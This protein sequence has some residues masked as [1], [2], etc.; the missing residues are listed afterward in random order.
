MAVEFV[1]KILDDLKE[2]QEEIATEKKAFS[3]EELY[4]PEPDLHKIKERKYIIE[5]WYLTSWKEGECYEV[6]TLNILAKN[7]KEALA[8]AKHQAPKG[9]KD[10]EII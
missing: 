9:A 4:P 2:L 1:K 5:Y 10:F 3:L 6:G 7:D 8:K